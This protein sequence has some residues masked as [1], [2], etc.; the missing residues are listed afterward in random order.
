MLMPEVGQL[1]S[2]SALFLN[3]TETCDQKVSSDEKGVSGGIFY[4]KV[5]AFVV[6]CFHLVNANPFIYQIFI[7]NFSP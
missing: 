5:M 1:I 6:F 7:I 3:Q 4:I 2:S